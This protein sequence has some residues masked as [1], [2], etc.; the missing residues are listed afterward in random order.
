MSSAEDFSPPLLRIRETPP[1]PLAGW[2]LR[3]LLALVAGVIAWAAFG[4]LDIVAVADG[5]LVPSGYLKIVQPAEQGILK[6][7]RVR[8]GQTVKEGEVLARMDPQLTEADVKV[9][10]AEYLSKRL[11]L[12]RVDAQLSGTSLQ[13]EPGDPPELHRQ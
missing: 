8:E 13:R 1:A 7:I 11:A 2:M 3:L 5:K 12:R 9:I 10:R 6:E 4:R